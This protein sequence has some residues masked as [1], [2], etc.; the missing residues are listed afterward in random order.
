MRTSGKIPWNRRVRDVVSQQGG[1]FREHQQFRQAGAGRGRHDAGLRQP[2]RGGGRVREL[3][4]PGRHGHR[5]VV[6]RAIF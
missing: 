6:R 1:I 5:E 2:G 4:R 3:G